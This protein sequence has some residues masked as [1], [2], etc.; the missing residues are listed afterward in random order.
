MTEKKQVLKPEEVLRVVNWATN[1]LYSTRA[2]RAADTGRNSRFCHCDCP[3]RCW[4]TLSQVMRM[5]GAKAPPP[6]KKPSSSGAAGGLGV[7]Q[8]DVESNAPVHRQV[9]DGWNERDRLHR[10]C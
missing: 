4:L 10:Y 3:L 7:S 1:Q 8:Y 9:V 6:R 5:F 2:S